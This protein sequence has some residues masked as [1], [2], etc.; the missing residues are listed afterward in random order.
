[1]SSEWWREMIVRFM[2]RNKAISSVSE[3]W[4]FFLHMCVVYFVFPKTSQIPL[5]MQR[6]FTVTAY[7]CELIK[8]SGQTRILTVSGA[9]S[10]W[11]RYHQIVLLWRCSSK[12]CFI[13]DRDVRCNEK[14]KFWERHCVPEHSHVALPAIFAC[15]LWPHFDV[16]YSLY[17]P[18]KKMTHFIRVASPLP[19]MQTAAKP[20]SCQERW[21]KGTV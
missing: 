3:K 6:S 16:S 18:G 4:R 17:K 20:I 21:P 14:A 7:L 13:A 8:Y 10:I 11:R 9:R 19:C 5:S 2:V 12:T 1:M 15:S